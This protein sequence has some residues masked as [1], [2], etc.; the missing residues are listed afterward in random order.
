M[1][2]DPHRVVIV[3]GGFGGLFAAR[4]LRRAP[5]QITLVDRVNHHLFQPLL[6]QV[7]TGI[8]SE[9][10]IAPP[11][12]G[13]LR[14]HDNVRVELAEVRS[15]DL[16]TRTVTAARPLGTPCTFDYDTLIVACG[17]TTSYFGQ[18]ELAEHSLP[19]KTIDDAL[20]LRRRI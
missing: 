5:V 18:D 17:A 11:L 1:V 15:F 12:R 4:A 16:E 13:I 20:N 9:G 19:M 6:Y 8:L 10:Q 7:A 2:P 3:G 14:K